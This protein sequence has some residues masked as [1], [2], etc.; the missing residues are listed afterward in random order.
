M[1]DYPT[2]TKRIRKLCRDLRTTPCPVSAVIPV[3]QESVDAVEEL[4]TRIDEHTALCIRRVAEV[5]A[6]RNAL[7][8]EKD[9]FHN[10][11]GHLG[12]T[13]DQVGNNM[14]ALVQALDTAKNG[15]LWYQ[16]TYPQEVN[17]CDDEAMAQIDAA[18]ALGKVGATP[19]APEVDDGDYC[20]H[21]FR[22]KP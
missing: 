18:L 3:L 21:C 17:G 1:I 4:Q 11:F 6:E 19:T 13:P 5:T 2:L 15:L 10:V 7:R 14:I 20:E 22:G 12:L 8:N 9:S 16:D